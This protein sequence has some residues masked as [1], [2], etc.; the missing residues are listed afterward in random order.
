M[1]RMRARRVGQFV[2]AEPGRLALGVL[3]GHQL[4]RA[5]PPPASVSSPR[6]WADSSGTPCARMAGSAGSRP[7]A[8]SARTSSSAPRRQHRREPRRDRRPQRR[9]AAGRAGWR[10]TARA[11]AARLLACQAA[12]PR[13]GAAPDL[14]GAGDALAVGR[15]QAA[16]PSPGPPRRAAHAARLGRSASAA[17]RASARAA[18]AGIGDIRQARRSARR[19]RGRCRRSG[20]AAGPPRA[21]R[22]ISASAASRHHATLPGSAAGRTPYSACGTGASSSGVGRAVSTRSSRYTCM[23]SALMIVP[24]KRSASSSASADLPLAVGPA[25]IRARGV[26]EAGA[27]NR[28]WRLRWHGV[29]VPRGVSAV[30]GWARFRAH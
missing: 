14:P 15:A 19:N 25:T 21:P 30:P 10:R 4:D 24:R 12:R 13:A 20:S 28:G 22:S 6:R 8:S 23:A 17:P 3:P 29:L 7:S 1:D 27:P 2:V 11:P 16:R 18:A 5:A 26:M 9:P